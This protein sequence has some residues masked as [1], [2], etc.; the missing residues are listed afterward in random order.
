MGTESQAFVIPA[1]LCY[2]HIHYSENASPS[3]DEIASQL[4]MSEDM[5]AEQI[6]ALNRRGRLDLR[7]SPVFKST[8]TPTRILS[9]CQ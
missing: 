8:N 1:H 2:L 3:T 7:M 6:A 4:H 9:L 5:A